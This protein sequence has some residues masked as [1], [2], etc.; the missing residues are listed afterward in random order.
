MNDLGNMHQALLA[1]ARGDSLMTQYNDV[2]SLNEEILRSRLAIHANLIAYFFVYLFKIWPSPDLLIAIGSLS[3]ALTGLG[4]YSF[5]RQV[6]GDESRSFLAASSF[7]ISPIVHDATLYDYHLITTSTAFVVWML[8]ALRMRKRGVAYALLLFALLCSE[9]TCLTI[10]LLGVWLI[11]SGQKRD[12][13]TLVATGCVFALVIF[14]GIFPFFNGSYISS[15]ASRRTEWIGSSVSECVQ[16]LLNEPGKVI[17]HVLQPERVL[18]LAYLFVAGGFLALPTKGILL[19]TLPAVAG[20]MLAETGWMTRVTGTYYWVGVFSIIV[21]GV[22]LSAEADSRS[23]S[24]LNRVKRLFIVSC[25]LSLLVSPVPYSAA[26]GFTGFKPNP[27]LRA[28]ERIEE[29]IPDDAAISAQNN[30]GTHFKRKAKVAAF[31]RRER[32][33]NYLVFHVRAPKG[34]GDPLFFPT[35]SPAMLFQLS[36]QELVTAVRCVFRRISDSIPS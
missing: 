10:S 25:L 24:P 32:L 11:A 17:A 29:L 12:G 22:V 21:L 9:D 26:S 27:D 4:I 13:M 14:V 8:V 7:W 3:C 34:G 19:A 16:T 33:S 36:P 28:L 6:L 5:T 15:V 35:S 30:L 31:P 2:D 20:A 18:L 1:L 23:G